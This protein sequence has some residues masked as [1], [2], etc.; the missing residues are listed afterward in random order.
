MSQR[1]GREQHS[2]EKEQH[3][4]NPCGRSKPGRG[5]T[6]PADS[7]VGAGRMN[8]VPKEDVQGEAGEIGRAGG[9]VKNRT[10]HLKRNGNPTQGLDPGRDMVHSLPGALS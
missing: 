4:Q 9:W 1:E 7:G 8:K 3:M 5:E 10:F 2:K 6:G